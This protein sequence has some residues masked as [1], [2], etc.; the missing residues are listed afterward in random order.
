MRL[1][2]PAEAVRFLKDLNSSEVRYL[3]I[4]GY[5]VKFYGCREAVED[6]DLLIDDSVENAERLYPIIVRVLGSTPNFHW[7][8]LSLPEKQLKISKLKIDILT[9][10]RSVAFSTA[11]DLRENSSERK[12]PISIISREH[13]VLIKK[14]A[15]RKEPNR[16]G[17]EEADI[18][19]LEGISPFLR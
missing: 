17:K 6:L 5:A 1:G 7:Q 19:C 14:E 4:G 8:E 9:S 10:S 18:N 16:R 12:V 3:V 15:L 13:L 11:Y 2:I